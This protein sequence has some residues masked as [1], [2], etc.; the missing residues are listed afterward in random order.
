MD[1]KKKKNQNHIFEKFSCIFNTIPLQ[2]EFFFS[3]ETSV[4]L[5]I[6]NIRL[7]KEQFIIG[8]HQIDVPI[9]KLIFKIR[10]SKQEMAIRESKWYLLMYI[11]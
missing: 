9:I 8:C 5:V 11:K 3:D 1:L 7:I 2:A 10:R 4:F 6:D